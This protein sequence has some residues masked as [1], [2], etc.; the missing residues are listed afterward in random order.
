MV[1]DIRAV[2]VLGAVGLF[3]GLGCMGRGDEPDGPTTSVA[4][5]EV[6]PGN[7]NYSIWSIAFTGTDTTAWILSTNTGYTTPVSGG[8]Y[9]IDAPNEVWNM[10]PSLLSLIQAGGTTDTLTFTLK[11]DL[12]WPTT[13]GTTINHFPASATVADM[14]QD[15]RSLTWTA[16]A[17]PSSV[18]GNNNVAVGFEHMSFNGS[19]PQGSVDWYYMGGGPPTGWLL[20]ST[21]QFIWNRVG[22]PGQGMSWYHA[23]APIT[24][25]AM[26]R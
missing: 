1:V 2:L 5:P 24:A 7:D 8:T 17:T 16:V 23:S 12:N 13:P 25:V 4:L 18:Y 9:T 14:P 19:T 26:T 21:E 20:T 15:V 6:D 10:P 11:G 22:T 3:A